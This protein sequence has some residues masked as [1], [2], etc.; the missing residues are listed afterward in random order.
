ML[1]EER[2][3]DVDVSFRLPPLKDALPK[4]GRLVPLPAKAVGISRSRS[5]DSACFDLAFSPSPVIGRDTDATVASAFTL[6]S[7]APS[8]RPSPR[9]FEETSSIAA[10]TAGELTSSAWTTRSAEGCSEG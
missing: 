4:G 5:S 10:V 8:A 7:G 1:E 3:Y 9:A 6:T 2:K